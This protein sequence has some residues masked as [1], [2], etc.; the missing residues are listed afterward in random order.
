MLWLCLSRVGAGLCSEPCYG[1]GPL[2]ALLC[3]EA[4]AA[5]A[6]QPGAPPDVR[7]ALGSEGAASLLGYLLSLLLQVSW[8]RATAL[9]AGL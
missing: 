5:G 7:Q 1:I 9:L 3:L 8:L 6:L 4:A 2:Q